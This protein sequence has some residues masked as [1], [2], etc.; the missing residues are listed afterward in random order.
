MKV[1]IQIKKLTRTA[2]IPTKGSD[3]AAGYDFYADVKEP[4]EVA[5][6]CTRKVGT[7]LAIA[8]D[9]NYWVGLFARSGLAT[10]E[11]LRPANCLGVIDSDYRGEVIAAIHNDS[12]YARI[13]EQGDRIGQLIIM[14]RFEWDIQEVDELDET[15]RGTGGFGSTGGR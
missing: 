4:V 7:G 15:V 11:G 2:T 12:D 14:P 9:E 13:I 10:K 1:P 6:H 3:Y 8:V 5:P